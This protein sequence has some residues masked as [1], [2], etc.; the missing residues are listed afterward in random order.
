[1]MHVSARGAIEDQNNKVTLMQQLLSVVSKDVEAIM[2]ISRSEISPN[3]YIAL[4]SCQS[5]SASVERSQDRKFLPQN[6][7]KYLV[8][9]YNYCKYIK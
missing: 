2:E 4:Q 9:H 5:T 3:N 8:L 1:M 7:G 6:V